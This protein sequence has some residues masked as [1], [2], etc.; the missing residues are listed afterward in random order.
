MIDLWSLGARRS[1]Q[2][3]FDRPPLKSFALKYG[4]EPKEG[5][6][7]EEETQAR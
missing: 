4:F 2:R 1:L 7:G 5:R 3:R 6:D